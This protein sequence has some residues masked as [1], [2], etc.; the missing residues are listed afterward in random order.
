MLGK[1]QVPTLI[2][3]GRDDQIVPIECAAQ[4][5]RAIPG[6]TVRILDHCGHFAHFEQPLLLAETIGGF[7]SP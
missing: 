3:W 5:Q 4:Y 6:A 1:I 7:I 2:V